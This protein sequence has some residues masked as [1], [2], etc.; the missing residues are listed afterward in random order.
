MPKKPLKPVSLLDVEAS[1]KTETG[2]TAYTKTPQDEQVRFT[3]I[4]T[5]E[6]AQR[7]R[8][9]MRQRGRLPRERNGFIR[10][11]LDDWLRGHNY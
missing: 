4:I 6:L 8:F 5:P 1:T 3:L 9:A 11:V 10:D 7:L 2:Y